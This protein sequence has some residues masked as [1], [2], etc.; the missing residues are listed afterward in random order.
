MSAAPVLKNAAVPAL[1]ATAATT[2][3]VVLLSRTNGG[4]FASGLNAISHM[5]WGEDAAR[6]DEADVKHTLTGAALNAAAV[7]GWAALEEAAVQKANI[8][9]KGLPMLLT[10]AAVSAAAY[11]TD[12]FLVPKRLTPGFEKRLSPQSMFVVYAALAGALAL[13]TIWGKKEEASNSDKDW[14][15]EPLL[16]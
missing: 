2:A 1:L 11:V 15:A 16:Q 12:Y 7:S 5:L 14:A 8:P 9:R 10:S 13:G 6:H 4:S 3:A